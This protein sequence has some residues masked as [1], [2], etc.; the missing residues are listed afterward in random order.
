MDIGR[1]NEFCYLAD[2][3]SFA[4][5]ARHF[6]MS[7]SVL[8]KHIAGIEGELD[9]KLFVRDS[10][11][12]RLT[13]QGRTFYDYAQSIIS[14]YDKA[15]T[16]LR[17][18]EDSYDEVVTIGYLRNAARP[19]LARFL[20]LVKAEHPEIHVA[21]RCMEYGEE[22]YAFLTKSIDMAFTLNI[23][24]SVTEQYDYLDIFPDRFDAIVSCNHPLASYDEVTTEQLLCQK[25]LLPDQSVYRGMRPFLERT[26]F[27]D[28]LR[29]NCGVYR[30]VDT[31]FLKVETE[32][33]VGFSSEHNTACFSQGVKF[34]PI[35]DADTSY[36]VSAF[37]PKNSDNTGIIACFSALEKCRDHLLK[38]FE[39][40]KQLSL[41]KFG[42]ASVNS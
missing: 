2:S 7:Q 18:I 5:T 1:L 32:G 4:D 3:L 33:Y 39:R 28:S 19:F 10:H 42:P 12:V 8:S 37:A 24:P 23:N 30:D 38:D 26:V 11:H 21:L 34:L 15:L 22:T 13:K 17:A 16:A 31:L 25:L 27:Q 29:S 6:F 35:S 9:A 36:C 40:R 14:Q 20:T 41:P